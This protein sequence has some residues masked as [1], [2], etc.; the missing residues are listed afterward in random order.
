MADKE[1]SLMQIRTGK[2]RNLPSALEHGELALTTDECRMF[3]GLPSTVTPASLV[4]G[5]TKEQE[6]G[7]GEEN[8][9]ILTE[10]T[11]LHVLNRAMYRAIKLDIPAAEWFDL[12]MQPT[13]DY[14]PGETIVN[15]GKFKLQIPSADRVFIDY[16]A[17]STEGTRVLE[18]GTLSV[19]IIDGSVLLQ[20]VNNT[21]DPDGL[22]WCEV[23]NFT[24]NDESDLP[25]V[26]GAM[27]NVTLRNQL[28]KNIRFEYIYRG[29]SEP[30]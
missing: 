27:T 26:D 5:R 25:T 24:S 14:V 30:I 15:P 9:E 16:V 22:I 13:T 4:A 21:N 1:I 7:S 17:F 11:P 20:Q 2:Q 10:F 6:P 19:V 28:N 3:S 18:T 8:V 12:L 23:S 29:W